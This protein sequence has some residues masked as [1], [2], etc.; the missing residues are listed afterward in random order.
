MALEAGEL[1]GRSTQVPEPPVLDTPG[2]I[3]GPMITKT[4]GRPQSPNDELP[5]FPEGWY[6]VATR[7]SI[8]QEK[9]IEKTWMGQEIVVWCDDEGR[10]CVSCR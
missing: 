5:P 7:D 2:R 4:D 8:L 3:T 6:F 9:L 10:V 1:A